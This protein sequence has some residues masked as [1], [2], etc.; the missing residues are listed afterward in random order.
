LESTYPGWRIL[1]LAGSSRWYAARLP[2]IT[3]AQASAGVV[4]TFIRGTYE[5]FGA[6]LAR[7]SGLVDRVGGFNS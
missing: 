6:A 4:A 2:P 5:E 1:Y 7:Q 3:A